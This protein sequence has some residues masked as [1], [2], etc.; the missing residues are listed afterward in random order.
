[1]TEYKQINESIWRTFGKNL[2]S[3]KGSDEQINFLQV[4]RNG[5]EDFLNYLEENLFNNEEA[6]I[7]G[8]TVSFDHKFT[9]AEFRFPPID[10]Q[11]IIWE[12]FE[13]I[14]REYMGHCGFW[15]YIIIQMI[16][17]D[18]IKP[19]YL[20]SNLNGVNE[21]GVYML[22]NAI[23]SNDGKK[24]DDCTRR[25]LRSM[26]NSAPRGKRIV[27]NDF[28]LGKAYW[29]WNWAN[30]MSREINLS[31][32]EVL[33]TLDEK[34]YT[35]FYQAMHTGGGKSYISQTNILGGLLLF[36]NKNPEILVKNIKKIIDIISYLSAWKAI[37]V[38][39]PELNKQEIQIIANNLSG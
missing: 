14:E 3:N 19:D 21:T 13:K 15:G 25:I 33:N 7:K 22:D 5:K 8:K 18:C 11:A 24:I 2:L 31:F 16:K 17:D 27:F 37:E 12:V 4:C 26:G 10:T 1:M 32:K 6:T 29:R 38:Q 9:E 30:K 35:E 20:A 39:S 34:G 36:L 23:N 28:Y